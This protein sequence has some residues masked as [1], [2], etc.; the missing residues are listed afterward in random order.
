MVSIMGGDGGMMMAYAYTVTVYKGGRPL[1]FTLIEMKDKRSRD[2]V[3]GTARDWPL[4]T[5]EGPIGMRKQIPKYQRE[6]NVMLRIAM[7]SLSR[8]LEAGGERMRGRSG[9]STLCGS[10]SDGCWRYRRRRRKQAIV[11]RPVQ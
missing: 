11:A 3:V 10:E 6:S 5:A 7:T 4:H 8:V 2:A 9:E 1:H